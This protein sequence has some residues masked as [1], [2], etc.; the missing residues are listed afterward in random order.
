VKA[1][2][3]Q[4][5]RAMNI[6]F[7]ENMELLFELVNI[8]NVREFVEIRYNV[9]GSHGPNIDL[10]KILKKVLRNSLQGKKANKSKQ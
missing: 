7:R 4:M 2:K 8:S 5:K 1:F 10:Y 9:E 3:I 6:K